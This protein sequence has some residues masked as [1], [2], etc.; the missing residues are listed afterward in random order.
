MLVA[1]SDES[2]LSYF[3]I[4]QQTE[5]TCHYTWLWVSDRYSFGLGSGGRIDCR[6]LSIW[7]SLAY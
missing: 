4:T 3:S 2:W 5:M 7:I 1:D 6:L